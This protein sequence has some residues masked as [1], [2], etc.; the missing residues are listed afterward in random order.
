MLLV[1]IQACLKRMRLD[2][3]IYDTIMSKASLKATRALR[4]F[5]DNT[6]IKLRGDTRNDGEAVG[7]RVTGTLGQGLNFAPPS[8]GMTTSKSLV[9]R[10]KDSEHLLAK[11]G[12][13]L[14]DPLSYVDNIVTM[15]KNEKSIKDTI[16]KT[17]K[18]RISK[19]WG[20][21]A[22]VKAV[23]NDAWMTKL[24]W[25][26]SGI[27]LVRA[28][29][30]PAL[31]YLADVFLGMNKCTEKAIA[32]AYKSMVYVVF[33]INTNTKWTSVLADLGLLNIMAV[34]DHSM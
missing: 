29:V 32:D 6:V 20:R 17:V 11:V 25:L 18:Y 26:G 22:K 4:K 10:F 1:D 5:S 3:V 28:V 8:I 19:A 31:T 13:V 15:P 14:T 16:N 12:D 21:V 30:I 2:N 27:T 23:I 33:D 9:T 7:R 24:G 34:I